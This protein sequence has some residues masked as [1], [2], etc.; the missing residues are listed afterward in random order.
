MWFCNGHTSPVCGIN[1]APNHL[2]ALRSIQSVSS[3]LESRCV[4]DQTAGPFTEPPFNDMPISGLGII[5]KKNGKFRVIHDL[6]APDG[7]S[8]ND[9]IPIEQFSLQYGSLDT[10][11]A[12]IVKVGPGAF[13][14][15]VDVRN[16]FRLCPVR[17]D[18]WPLL[19]IKWQNCYFHEKVLPFGLRSS[20]FIFNKF[21]IAINWLLVN[22]GKLPEVMYYLDDFLDICAPDPA[23]AARHKDIF[24]QLFDYQWLPKKSKALQQC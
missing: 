1:I 3:Y 8:V 21:A 5:P 11:I 24:L 22:V 10:A 4:S 14:T 17:P 12:A 16:A 13:L 15:K 9:A 20:P 6:S 7:L 2:S 19:G 23:L 18:D